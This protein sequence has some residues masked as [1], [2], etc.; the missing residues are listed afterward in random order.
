MANETL[1]FNVKVD[2]TD[3]S[4]NLRKFKKQAIDSG[5]KI[6]GVWKK[7]AIAGAFTA[8]AAGA[9]AFAKATKAIV[10]TYS[11]FEKELANVSTLV[12][13][14]TVSM[15]KLKD[16]IL[17]LPSIMGSATENTKALYQ[18]ISAGVK[19]SEAVKLIEE[20]AKAAGAG[21]TSTFTAVEGGTTI[22]NAYGLSALGITEIF[23][24]MFTAVKAGKTTFEE[25]SSSIGKVAPVASAVG[26]STKEL[27]T[28]IATLTK[29]GISTSESITALKGA[30]SNIIK[31]SSEAAKIAEKM[32]IAF[33]VSEL[34]SKGFAGFLAEIREKTGGNVEAM[35]KLFGSVEALNAILA[36]TSDAGFADFN[37]ILGEM[38][39]SSGATEE[40]FGKMRR[41]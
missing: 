16:E 4:R 24:Q 6:S 31:P 34:K 13:T 5:T 26:V 9:A 18:A 12:D 8:A 21:L 38:E 28:A 2:A 17:A 41:F 23:D 10:T 36:L 40:A 11:S 14:N 15:K 19:P 3:A 37:K 32:G 29:Q 33:S 20:S 22:L 25:L 30:F 1:K 7:V 27:F 35:S 39:Q